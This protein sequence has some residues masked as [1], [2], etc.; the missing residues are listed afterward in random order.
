MP[1][2]G[3][4]LRR[5]EGMALILTVGMLVVLGLTGGTLIAYTTANQG[6]AHRHSADATAHKLAEAGINNAFAVLSNPSNNALSSLLLPPTLETANVSN[7]DEG[8]VKW[9]GTFSASN[10]TWS[11]SSIGYVRNPTP[12]AQVPVMRRISVS[13]RVRGSFM[14]PLNNPSW[15]YIMATRTGTPGGCDMTLD[16]SIDMQSPLYVFGNL[17]LNTPSQITGG[18]LVVKGSVKLDV[19]TNIGSAANPINEAHIKLGCSYKNGPWVA[20]CTPTENVWATISDTNPPDLA[21]PAADFAGW[22][23]N[24][25]PGPRQACTTQSGTIPVFDNDLTMNNSVPGVF[26]LTPANNSYSCVVKNGAGTTVGELTWNTTTEVLTVYGTI[27]IDGSVTAD[28]GFQNVAIQYNG[29]ASLYLGGTFLA[30]NT[31]ICGGIS[32]ASC[33]FSAWN[34]NTEML[35]IVAN[36]QG[37]QV[38]SG[39]GIQI[40]NSHIQGALWSSN[41]I[42][43]DTTSN[44]EGPMVASTEII[45]NTV[46]THSWPLITTV[47]VG[48][49]GTPTVYAQ[50]DPPGGYTS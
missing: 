13:T 46:T 15:N 16:N 7:Y 26:N 8:Y 50:P 19:N 12:G 23:S 30:S 32:G 43:L 11:L 2:F 37:G 10:S 47:P 48:M 1:R 28:Y 45:G 17:C 22:Y 24:A 5:E 21:P 14:Q 38:P 25:V 34:P 3:R 44:T 36:G 4:L 42:E 18:P 31:K 9:W 29:Q 35:V 33:D 20:P 41:A 40:K 6:A 39:I 27:F 49:P